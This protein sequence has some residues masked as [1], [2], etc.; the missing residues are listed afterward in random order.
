M[1]ALGFYLIAGAAVI[2]L[3]VRRHKRIERE[4]HAEL[5][6]SKAAGLAE[7][8]SLH[9]II[10]PVLCMGSGSCVAACPEEALGIVGGK[11]V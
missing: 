7:P 6:A 3:Y 9:P 4:H 11:A 2:G 1:N 10:N 5:E 8:A